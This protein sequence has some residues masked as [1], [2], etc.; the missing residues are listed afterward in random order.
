MQYVIY[1]HVTDCNSESSATSQQYAFSSCTISQV[2]MQSLFYKL[3]F[4]SFL[5]CLFK[6]CPMNR[7]AAQKQWI[8][9][10]K[11][12]SSTSRTDPILMRR[13]HV[14]IMHSVNLS[15]DLQHEYN[16]HILWN[17]ILL[18]SQ[19]TFILENAPFNWCRLVW[20]VDIKIHY[21]KICFKQHLGRKSLLER[22][23]KYTC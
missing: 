14:S 9:A 11:Q 5:D 18:S 13:L 7:Y 21:K 17:D 23:H 22:R 10:A 3:Y 1:Q 6:I 8:K 12:S 15:Q 19:I 4:L 16:S 2:T 20:Y